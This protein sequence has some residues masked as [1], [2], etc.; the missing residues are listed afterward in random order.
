VASGDVRSVE[1]Q[2]RDL[3]TRTLRATSSISGTVDGEIQV[4]PVSTLADGTLA[5]GGAR[6]VTVVPPELA[7]V[8]S[9]DG[10]VAHLTPLVTGSGVIRCTIGTATA[11]EIPIDIGPAH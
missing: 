5:F 10:L 1:V 6:S 9:D 2:Q 11:A 4:A 3:M 7:I 8:Q